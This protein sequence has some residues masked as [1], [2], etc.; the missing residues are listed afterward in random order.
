MNSLIVLEARVQNQYHWAT[1]PL[2]NSGPLPFLVSPRSGSCQHSLSC[3]W[4][5]L[6]SASVGH[7][8]CSLVVANLPLP[9]SFFFLTFYFIL[10]Y[11]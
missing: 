5:T 10:E 6:V 1:L 7:V 8:A 9:V 3:G 2:E 11:S 4:I